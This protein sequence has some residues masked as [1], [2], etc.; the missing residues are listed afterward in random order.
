[1][2]IVQHRHDT[3]VPKMNIFCGRDWGTKILVSV[4]VLALIILWFAATSNSDEDQMRSVL[5]IVFGSIVCAPVL[6][7][8]AGLIG[9]EKSEC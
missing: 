2:N 3:R 7:I 5:L 4:G 8:G 1:M 6:L 9:L